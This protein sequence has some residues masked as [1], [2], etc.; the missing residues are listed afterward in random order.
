MRATRWL[1]T[2]ALGFL[3]L[4][5]GLIGS[6]LLV[7]RSR[8]EP[9]VQAPVSGT[10]LAEARAVRHYANR[11][12]GLVE[13]YLARVPLEAPAP[14]PVDEAWIRRTFT[15]MLR[16]LRGEIQQIPQF[17]THAEAARLREAL[18]RLSAMARNPSDRALRTRAVEE[19]RRA[20]ASAEAWIAAQGLRGQLGEAARITEF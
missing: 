11:I 6:F 15:A 14:T 1:G 2:L 10:T 4:A 3:A 5:S 9:A 13:A 12:A 8:P 19:C 20:I 16:E 17:D 7:T 18:D